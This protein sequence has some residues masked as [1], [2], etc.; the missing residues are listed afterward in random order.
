MRFRPFGKDT[1]EA[2]GRQ[3]SSCGAMPIE[4]AGSFSSGTCQKS[5]LKCTRKSCSWEAFL[6][7]ICYNTTQIEVPGGCC[8]EMQEPSPG[9]V[10]VTAGAGWRHSAIKLSKSG[11]RS[12]L[13]VTG[14]L[15]VRNAA[16]LVHW[17]SCGH[18]KGSHACCGILPSEPTRARRKHLF[19]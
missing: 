10:A 2:L 18:L 6:V 16:G 13:L 15:S 14:V 11:C 3:R 7:V 1:P 12:L 17:G 5:A 19:F 9:E 4:A 8:H